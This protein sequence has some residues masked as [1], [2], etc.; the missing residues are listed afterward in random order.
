MN[1]K[2][3]SCNKNIKLSSSQLH[4]LRNGNNNFF[5]SIKCQNIWQKGKHHNPSTE[6]KPGRG[7]KSGHWQGG[8]NI[9]KIGYVLIYK[10]NHPYRVQDKYVLEHRYIMEQKIG[11]FLKPEERVHHLN[12]NKSDNRI[13]NLVLF[14][15]ESEHQKSH[16][17]NNIGHIIF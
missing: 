5:C 6:F 16:I 2:C 10:P 13:E 9:T 17:R 3:K 12:R 14:S 7:T 15:S 8:R 1:K 11:R 4:R